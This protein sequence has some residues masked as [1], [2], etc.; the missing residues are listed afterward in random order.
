[1]AYEEPSLK[2]LLGRRVQGETGKH[3]NSGYSDYT[4]LSLTST[5]VHTHTHL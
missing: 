5:S 3:Q 1:M 4:R 2:G